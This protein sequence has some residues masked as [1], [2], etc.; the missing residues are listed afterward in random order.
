MR[1]MQEV[2]KC[3]NINILPVTA[4]HGL[5]ESVFTADSPRDTGLD[6]TGS[7]MN[8]RLTRSSTMD[9]WLPV[10]AC[11]CRDDL[12]PGEFLIA[13]PEAENPGGE[14]PPSRGGRRGDR[15]QDGGDLNSNSK[16]MRNG[17]RGTQR[18]RNGSNSNHISSGDGNSAQRMRGASG[19]IGGSSAQTCLGVQ[20]PESLPLDAVGGDINQETVTMVWEECYRAV[21]NYLP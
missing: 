18:K 13:G 6:V 16:G 4:H 8:T 1:G 12:E 15:D 17:S 10:L 9:T 11:I 2:M 5:H 3:A 20:D 19:G 7:L 21:C 14:S